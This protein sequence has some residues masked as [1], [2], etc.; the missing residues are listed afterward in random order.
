MYRIE[1][2]TFLWNKLFFVWSLK[3]DLGR[4]NAHNHS[5]LN[6][7]VFSCVFILHGMC[8]QAF[9]M[10]AIV[11]HMTLSQGCKSMLQ[12]PVNGR[13]KD[14]AAASDLSSSYVSKDHADK[15]NMWFQS[16]IAGR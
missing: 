16:S 13:K 11:R 15:S 2:F 7:E 14:T 9:K 10:P 1:P 6:S 12:I 3:F 4:Q 8:L 5:V